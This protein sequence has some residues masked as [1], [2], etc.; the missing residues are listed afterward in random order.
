MTNLCGSKSCPRVLKPWPRVHE[1]VPNSMPVGHGMTKAD[2]HKLVDE[3]P[4]IADEVAGAL[5]RGCLPHLGTT[6]SSARRISPSTRQG[7]MPLLEARASSGLKPSRGSRLQAEPPPWRIVI[8]PVAYTSGCANWD[9]AT[10]S[11]SFAPSMRFPLATF[12]R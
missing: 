12:G 9:A 11:G 8:A 1:I 10:V 5:L 4:E 3:L 6:S 7:S 2:L